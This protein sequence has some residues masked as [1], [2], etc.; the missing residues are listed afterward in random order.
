MWRTKKKENKK[1]SHMKRNQQILSV[2]TQ[3]PIHIKR[4]S[5]SNVAFSNRSTLVLAAIAN[6]Y[7]GICVYRL[8][9]VLNRYTSLKPAIASM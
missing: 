5:F 3:K 4:G 8:K 6:M 9:L 7:Q 1:E 2:E